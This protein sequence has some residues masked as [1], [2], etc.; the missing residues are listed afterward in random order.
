MLYGRTTS[1]FLSTYTLNIKRVLATCSWVSAAC[2]WRFLQSHRAAP[3]FRPGADLCFRPRTDLYPHM[4]WAG[5]WL[6]SIRYLG[7]FALSQVWADRDSGIDLT[8]NLF[9]IPIVITETRI[10]GFCLESLDKCNSHCPSFEF[11]KDFLLLFP[12]NLENIFPFITL[13][14]L[15]AA[16]SP[17]DSKDTLSFKVDKTC[18]IPLLLSYLLFFFLKWNTVQ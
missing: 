18:T 7:T 12:L 14:Q 4:D 8:E 15:S 3:S 17:P 10:K 6:T 11:F 1:S 9:V 5:F 13:S 16:G 2:D